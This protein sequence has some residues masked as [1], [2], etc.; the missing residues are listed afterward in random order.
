[1]VWS[2][3]CGLGILVVVRT[4]L[5][6]PRVIMSIQVQWRVIIIYGRR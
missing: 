4:H 6:K 1:M 5:D 2:C 3:K